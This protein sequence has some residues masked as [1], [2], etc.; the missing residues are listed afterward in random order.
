MVLDF[1]ELFYKYNLNIN[2]VIHVGGHYGTEANTY[3][4][5]CV[6]KA[7][8]FEPLSRNFD[9]LQQNIFDYQAV[10]CALGSEEKLY[11]MFVEN[12]NNSQSSSLKNPINI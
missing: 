5:F 9:I 3:K 4:R 11:E 8:F 10:K 7:I 1:H 12:N 2:G 6:P